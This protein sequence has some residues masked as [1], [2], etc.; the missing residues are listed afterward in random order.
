[1]NIVA[2]ED[3]FDTTSPF[4][5]GMMIILTVVASWEIDNNEK[6]R[7]FGIEQAKKFGTRSGKPFGRPRAKI[8]QAALDDL[9]RGGKVN[10]LRAVSERYG[11][12][13][14]TLSRRSKTSPSPGINTDP[15]KTGESR[16]DLLL[17][18]ERA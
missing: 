16:N 18:Q 14:A 4:M 6:R 8:P 10:S 3:G 2:T 9:A 13:L 7:T 12:P 15:P 17:E 1:V 11:V 5:A